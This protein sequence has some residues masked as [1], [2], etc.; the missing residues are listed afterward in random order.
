[1]LL[2]LNVYVRIV[3]YISFAPNASNGISATY[4]MIMNK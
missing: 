3:E 2:Y 1:M 4:K